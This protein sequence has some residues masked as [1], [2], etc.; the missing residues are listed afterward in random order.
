MLGAK[1]QFWTAGWKWKVRLLVLGLIGLGAVV[2]F[3]HAS[4]FHTALGITLAI[5]LIVMTLSLQETAGLAAAFEHERKSHRESLDQLQNKLR[6]IQHFAIQEKK[7]AEQMISYLKQELSKQAKLLDDLNEARVEKF[8]LSVLS[9]S[10]R[11]QNLEKEGRLTALREELDRMSEELKKALTVQQTAAVE[12]DPQPQH[13]YK[14]LKV[15]F[16]E[17]SE[18]LHRTRQELF[19][20]EGKLHVLQRESEEV[21]FDPHLENHCK[22]IEAECKDL[23]SQVLHLEQIISAMLPKK[24]ALRAKKPKKESLASNQA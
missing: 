2:G 13:D 20:I 23:E 5:G 24:K 14:Q 19:Q 17:K 4:P 16:E 6:E 18:V 10:N 22:Q 9:E 12:G 15:Q 3:S 8:Q 11:I 21:N 1:V 7:E